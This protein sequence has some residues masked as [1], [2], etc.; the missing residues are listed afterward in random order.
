MLLGQ[1]TV[2]IKTI[3]HKDWLRS[4]MRVTINQT[5]VN[6]YAEEMNQGYLFPL[7][8]VFVDTDGN[9]WL[10]DGFHRVDAY[11]KNGNKSIPIDLKK[12]TLFDAILWNITANRDQ[13]G[14]PFTIGDKKKSIIT[15]L[16]NEKSKSWTL[17]KIAEIIGCCRGYVG[18]V[19]KR[20][21][22]MRP[23]LY[24][25]KKQ[26]IH[27]D[28]IKRRE[29]ILKLHL[30]GHKNK[31]IAEIVGMSTVTIH[32][33]IKIATKESS[34]IPCPHCNGTGMISNLD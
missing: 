28:I 24:R 13:K 2:P 21:P 20:L 34:L 4:E 14:L 3:R 33:D 19:C 11:I 22:E 18:H 6:Q 26:H 10:G 27:E 8:V 25:N 30:E 12:G 9:R 1:Q 29:K 31:E 7:P 15:L 32:N 17:V 23:S 5:K 16:T